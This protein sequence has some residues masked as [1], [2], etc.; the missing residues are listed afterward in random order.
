M[1]RK[2]HASYPMSKRGKHD[3]PR[4]L[5]LPNEILLQIKSHL[6]GSTVYILRR[7]CRRFFQLSE[8]SQLP[9]RNTTEEQINA[10]VGSFKDLHEKDRGEA[11]MLLQRDL[12]CDSCRYIRPR[13][14]RKRLF[15]TLWCLGCQENHPRLLFSAEQGRKRGRICIGL[16]FH[17][18][19]CA[20]QGI[21]WAN[22]ER[23][24][25]QCQYQS[26]TRSVFHQGFSCD[27]T[28]SAIF[29]Y[30]ASQ[31]KSHLHVHGVGKVGNEVRNTDVG[32]IG[33]LLCSHHKG[34]KL[35]WVLEQDSPRACKP[36]QSGRESDTQAHYQCRLCKRK[37]HLRNDR[38]GKEKS[39]ISDWY[40][41]NLSKPTDPEWLR[42][43][44][45]ESLDVDTDDPETKGVLWCGDQ[46]C[47][48]S[49]PRHRTA[50][51]V[52]TVQYYEAQ[53][54]EAKKLLDK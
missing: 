41:R 44:D 16:E 34:T 47:V 31:N 33:G 8:K 45:L 7:T 40:I 42:V 26:S 50:V 9:A 48:V 19:L 53:M 49:Q 18:L 11:K 46:S 13:D 37:T 12:F 52:R 14:D 24:L 36:L 6:P 22:V 30:N 23:F 28:L 3:K 21:T 39:F 27:H 1:K 54:K 35:P 15:E 29:R 2:S 10:R 43:V 32:N 38:G 51:L 25:E 5:D 4:L 20:C 17:V